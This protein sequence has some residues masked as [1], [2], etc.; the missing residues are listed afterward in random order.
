MVAMLNEPRGCDVLGKN[1]DSRL[2]G[3]KR[4][5]RTWKMMEVRLNGRRRISRLEVAGFS[6][7]PN[8]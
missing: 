4:R 8:G 5:Q 6:V 2:N 3:M 1:T 7:W